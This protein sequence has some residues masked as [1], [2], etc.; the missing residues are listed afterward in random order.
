MEAD[1]TIPCNASGELQRA[2]AVVLLLLLLLLLGAVCSC[3][4]IR[5]ACVA[6]CSSRCSVQRLVDTIWAA[7]VGVQQLQQLV[8]LPQE[9]LAAKACGQ[10]V[11]AWLGTLKMQQ[12]RH[13]NKHALLNQMA[14]AQTCPSAFAPR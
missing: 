11:A 8:S 7:V 12:R 3:K 6:L 10:S 5:M 14:S 1:L 9:P 2:P 4:C 13:T